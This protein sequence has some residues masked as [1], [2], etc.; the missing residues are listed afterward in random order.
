MSLFDLSGKVGLVTGGNQGLGLGFATGMAKCGADVVIWGR[1]EDRNAE[2]AAELRAYGVR[3]LTQEVDV[4]DE[5]AVREAMDTAATEMGRIDCVVANAGTNSHP[6][7]FHE[8][9]S[10]MYHDLLAVSQHGVFYTLR[11][12]V[13]HMKAR[14][15]AGDP[16]GSLIACGSLMAIRGAA[17]LEHY[18]AAKAAALAMVR[19]IA[20]EYGRHGIR[21]NMVAAG[22]FDTD[23]TR[24]THVDPSR[25][26][27]LGSRYPIPRIGKPSDLEGITAYLMSDASSYHTGDLIVV[28]GGLSI[29]V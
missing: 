9:P 1:R 5:Q 6:P 14:A 26:K 7:S 17:T 11:E 3:V 21:A 27:K 8:M 19:G 16:G 22:Y 24:S 4:R 13:K 10:E 23:L 20:V 2:A 25:G 18:G 29:G 12:A 15:D 28:D